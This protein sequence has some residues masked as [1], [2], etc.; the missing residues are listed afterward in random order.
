MRKD[1]GTGLLEGLRARPRR[2]TRRAFRVLVRAGACAVL[3]CA[4]ATSA[5]AQ[6]SAGHLVI[7]SGLSGEDRFARDY[8]EWGSGL[9]A[10]AVERYGLPASNV[11]WLA[12]DDAAH[13]GIR[14]RST[15][16]NVERELRTLSQRAAAND[17]IL[18]VI[19]GHGSYQSGESRINL[20][21]PDIDGKAFAGL[22][23]PLGTQRVA[24]VNA[25][26]A[27]G[28]F[29]Q[30]LAGPNRIVITATKSGM[31]ANETVFGRHFAAALTGDAADTNKDGR[32]SLLEAFEYTRLEVE[33]EY[34][35]GNK[36]QTEHALLDAVGD[37]KGV[38]E[39]AAANPHGRAAG[40]FH[41]GS[42]GAA[43]A[44]ASPELRALY[45]EKAR[46]EEALDAL[47]ARKDSMPAAEYESALEKLLVDLS[48][49]AQSIR[50]LEGGGT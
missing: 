34:Q 50:R 44:G 24:V 14:A 42:V 25:T 2:V 7:I 30:D 21:G 15:R 3:S 29:I 36:L 5:S 13:A 43:A 40:A 26:S 6:E 37:G 35:R 17:R 8:V 1:I 45:A 31:E 9:A 33:R 39:V 41:L 48:R 32:V 28:G 46:I 11:V 12:E 49:N 22:L 4:A 20:P 18:I 47:R 27:S 38:T 10:A 23:A 19:F 16:E